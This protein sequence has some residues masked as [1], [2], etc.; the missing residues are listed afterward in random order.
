LWQWD[1]GMGLADWRYVVRIANI[2]LSDW[3]GATGTQAATAA[4]NVLNL[5]L[6]AIARIPNLNKG[7]AVFYANRSVQEGMQVQAL[8]RSTNALGLRQAMNQFGQNVHELSFQ[9]I[10]I[11]TVDALGI[12]ETLVS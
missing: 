8:N 2:D 11:R 1:A 4:T 10:P 5:M 9:G 7:R 3:L 6:K 12:A